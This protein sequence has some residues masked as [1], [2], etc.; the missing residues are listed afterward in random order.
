MLDKE[1]NFTL[2][3]TPTRRRLIGGAAEQAP[4]YSNPAKQL[5]TSKLEARNQFL[6]MNLSNTVPS[7][8]QL[9]ESL[10]S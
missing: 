3:A 10:E 6:A 9:G 7:K 1:Y 2:S 4:D 5:H 8:D